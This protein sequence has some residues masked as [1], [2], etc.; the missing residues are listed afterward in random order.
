MS[1]ATTVPGPRPA[2]V[3]PASNDADARPAAGN[4]ALR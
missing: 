4:G 1:A 3:T 2:N